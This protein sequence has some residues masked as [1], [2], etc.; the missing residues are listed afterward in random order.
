MEE[1]DKCYSVATFKWH[2]QIT[3]RKG[4]AVQYSISGGNRDGLFTIHQHSGAITLAATLDHE[5]RTQVT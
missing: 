1:I 4:L 3:V 2:K 5:Y